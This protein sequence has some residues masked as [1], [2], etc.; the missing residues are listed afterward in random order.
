ME[1]AQ[2]FPKLLWLATVC[3]FILTVLCRACLDTNL[4]YSGKLQFP[5]VP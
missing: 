1:V 2:T 4:C 5:D 3:S